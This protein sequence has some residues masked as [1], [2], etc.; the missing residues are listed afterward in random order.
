MRVQ[1]LRVHPGAYSICR[2]PAGTAVAPGEP[3]YAW[4]QTADETSVVCALG[5][6]PQGARIEGDWSLLEIAGPFAFTEC[7]I[8]VS[9]LAPLAEAEIGIF[10]ISTFDTDW[11]LVKT[12]NMERAVKTLR[13][14]GHDVSLPGE[15]Q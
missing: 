6:E 10:A 3:F 1:K 9:V 15:I 2:L 11:L 8:L 13:A 14:S 7:G 4:T 5:A 12:V